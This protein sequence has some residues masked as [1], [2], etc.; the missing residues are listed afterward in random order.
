[1][2]NPIFKMMNGGNNRPDMMTQFK[3]FM[4]Q[5]RGQN[6]NEILNNLVSSGKINQAHFLISSFTLHIYIWQSKTMPPTII[7][8]CESVKIVDNHYFTCYIHYNTIIYICQV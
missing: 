5:M 6:P 4:G 8:T 1:M 2:A 3:Q 7:Y